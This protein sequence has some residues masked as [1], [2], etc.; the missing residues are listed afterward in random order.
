MG[1]REPSSLRERGAG[2]GGVGGLAGSGQAP[3]TTYLEVGVLSKQVRFLW[4]QKADPG[5]CGVRPG[6]GWR[7]QRETPVGHLAELSPGVHSEE[8][9]LGCKQTAEGPPQLWISKASP[10]V[11][12][13]ELG[14]E[15]TRA[16]GVFVPASRMSPSC[17]CS[18]SPHT[19]Y[20]SSAGF[21]PRIGAQY[22]TG[23]EGLGDLGDLTQQ[24]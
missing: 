19:E 13:P 2:E 22:R 7:P 1:S 4:S 12:A 10:E 17:I 18:F 14:M 24:G 23:W 3:V 21:P 16:S 6:G 15:G 20:L 8:K 5:P 11:L 9:E